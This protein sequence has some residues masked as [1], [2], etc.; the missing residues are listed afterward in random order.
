MSTTAVLGCLFGDEAKAKIVDVLASDADIIVRFQGGSNAGH[1]IQFDNHKFVMHLIPSGIF[2][3]EKK[4]A[5]G[6]GVV[7]DPVQ[8]ENEMSALVEKGI[9][10]KGRFFIDERASIVLPIHK[11]LDEKVETLAGAKKIGTT[12]RGIGPCYSDSISRLGLRICDLNDLDF[13]YYR[14][15]FLYQYHNIQIDDVELKEQ[16]DSLYAFGQRVNDYKVNL[17]YLL[18]QY[19]KDNKD[20]LFEGAQGTLLDIYFGTYPYVTS[21]HTVSGGISVATGFPPNQID[22]LIG[23]F[24]SYFTR[25]G[26][27]PFPTEQDNPVGEQIRKQG[28]EYGST[29]GRPRR[30]G[31]FDVV[32]A[33]FSVMIN[34]IDSVAL[35]L[36]DVLSGLD[37][38][39]ICTGYKINGQMI[40][41]FPSDQRI[42]E[43]AEPVYISM[44]TW[45]EDISQCKTWESL[46]LNAQLYVKKIESL[47]EIPVS[48]VSVGPKRDQTIFLMSQ[49]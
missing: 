1:T 43:N 25:V 8:L 35:T 6:S 30:C 46:P 29:T 41:E 47:L 31:W 13:I 40:N 9:T 23:V 14:L 11:L 16:S 27:G 33:K 10:F 39:K 24:K 36:L 42:L 18:D 37:E 7:I 38:L 44:N 48:I 19:Y 12:K 26:S 5:L 4:C 32:A 15:S 17:P 3:S 34:G 22:L 21:S 49:E 28:N 2:H 45:T 20:I